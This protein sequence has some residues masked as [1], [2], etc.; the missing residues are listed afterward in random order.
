MERSGVAPSGD[1]HQR[2]GQWLPIDSRGDGVGN[3]VSTPVK[4]KSRSGPHHPVAGRYRLR[5]RGDGFE[6][7]H[8]QDSTG[9]VCGAGLVRS[10]KGWALDHRTPC[11]RIVSI[12]AC[13]H[14]RGV[15]FHGLCLGTSGWRAGRGICNGCGLGSIPS[16]CSS[17]FGRLGRPAGGSAD[18][19]PFVAV[20]SGLG[21]SRETSGLVAFLGLA[22]GR[23]S[24]PSRFFSLKR[25]GSGR[26][27]DLWSDQKSKAGDRSEIS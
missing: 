2:F 24:S 21:R 18:G 14:C 9:G 19:P 22:F 7:A 25:S 12:R 16:G 20:G 8:R 27:R 5:G 11:L 3:L 6:V 15:G 1:D 23:K 17:G 10:T 4:K 26:F 13:F